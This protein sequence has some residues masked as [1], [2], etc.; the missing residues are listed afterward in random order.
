[1]IL[2]TLLTMISTFMV[3]QNIYAVDCYN[4]INWNDRNSPKTTLCSINQKLRFEKIQSKKY[5]NFGE[6]INLAI[7][8]KSKGIFPSMNFEFFEKILEKKESTQIIKTFIAKNLIDMKEKRDISKEDLLKNLNLNDLMGE[9]IFNPD[10][11]PEMRNYVSFVSFYILNNSIKKVAEK[12]YKLDESLYKNVLLTEL[13]VKDLKYKLLDE[14]IN[15]NN[16]EKLITKKVEDA[17]EASLLSSIQN[18][19]LIREL[20][21]KIKKLETKDNAKEQINDENLEILNAKLEDKIIKIKQK[22]NNIEFQNLV[23]ES[24]Y[25]VT[26]GSSIISLKYPEYGRKL[27]TIGQSTLSITSNFNK[28]LL[29]KSSGVAFSMGPYA[30]IAVAAFEI[31]SVLSENKDSPFKTL[32]NQILELSKQVNELRN[33]MHERFER[34]ELILGEIYKDIMDEFYLLNEGVS[35]IKY[36]ISDLRDKFKK[37]DFKIKSIDNSLNNL[38]VENVKIP[39]ITYLNHCNNWNQLYNY[40]MQEEKAMTCYS[41]M[42]DWATEYSQMTTLTGSM[43]NKNYNPSNL[44]QWAYQISKNI[45]NKG[46]E[47]SINL[48]ADLIDFPY[49][50]S[51]PLVWA[52]GTMSFM[53][54]REQQPRYG[55]MMTKMALENIIEKGEIINSFVS[56][57]FHNRYPIQYLEKRYVSGISAV[58][59]R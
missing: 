30:A 48:L 25:F 58:L 18:D 52:S 35:S 8:M 31:I 7:S 41:K 26:F 5:A 47:Y 38:M 49:K 42:Y 20:K 13:E 4:D 56:E 46:Y 1:L 27:Q 34:I 32:F 28:I 53:H 14:K 51:N 10:L 12:V 59:K 39:F 24:S 16:I 33:E 15:R 55:N 2:K 11:T 19:P 22:F 29:N 6:I 43:D 23:Q 21:G 50:L 45:D 9:L 3:F 57:L 37:I 40:P 44:I 17:I 54:M 36:K